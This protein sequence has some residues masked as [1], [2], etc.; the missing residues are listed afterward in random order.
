MVSAFKPAT[1][2]QSKARIAVIGVAGAGKTFTALQIAKGLGERIAV[3]DTEHGSASKYAD[4]R[5][6]FD[7]VNLEEHHPQKFIDLIAD[8]ESA[9]DV[10]IIDSYSHAWM[11]NEGA[12]ELVDAAARRSKAGNS[13]AAWRDVTPL[14]NK[15]V[16]KI[17]GAKCH[18]I[19]TLRAKME[20]VLDK[21]EKTG[22]TTPRK[23][24]LA[25]VQRDSVEYIFD[26]VGDIDLDHYMA[27]T[28]S[29]CTELADK[30]IA[31]P[32]VEL[33]QQIRRWLSDGVIAS[34]PAPDEPKEDDSR[35]R[36]TLLKRIEK[37]RAQVA[38]DA[39][40]HAIGDQRDHLQTAA[41]DSLKE[42]L[43]RLKDAYRHPPQSTPEVE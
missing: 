12:L 2:A 10:V 42:A 27:I 15:L 21:D 31:K 6:A 11:G 25:P 30:V 28:K 32:G 38:P 18:V 19:V 13:F 9:Y 41:I 14:H 23:V 40:R 5:F 39:Y 36:Q 35:E 34:V 43:A 24:G 1:K 8:A 33:G 22:K 4:G 16:E 3:I 29:R 20:Y 37:A 26:I 17:V 7:V